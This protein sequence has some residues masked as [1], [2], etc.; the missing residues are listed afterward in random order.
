VPD[1]SS[2]TRVHEGSGMTGSPRGEVLGM[3]GERRILSEILMPRLAASKG[4]LRDIGDDCAEIGPVAGDRTLLVTTDPCPSPVVFE[5]EDKDY[6]HYG[7]MTILINVSDLAAM[8]AIPMGIAVSTV[9][10]NEMRV[11]DYHRFLDG[12]IEAADE[13]D[14]PVIG[15]NIKDGPAFTST[16]TALGS[17]PIGRVLKRT[18]ARP[19]DKICVVGRMGLFW[20]AV[21]R[22]MSSPRAEVCERCERDLHDAL[23]RPKAR[24]REAQVLARS[25]LVTACMDA[26]DGVGAC[27]AELAAKNRLDLMVDGAALVPDEPVREVAGQLGVDPR[28][29]LLSWGNWELVFTVRRDATEV[30]LDLAREHN[31][32]AAIIGEMRE[33]AGEVWLTSADEKYRLTDFSSERFTNTSY[34]THGVKSYMEWLIDAPL[35][36]GG[37]V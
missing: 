9:M 21:L 35:I 20:A 4:G 26:S 27:L 37:E 32:P 16:G 14:C 2:E 7:Y 13:W 29:L 34:F 33:G 15:G 28:K 12:L 5:I 25:G 6:W 31:F 30:M 36:L 10:P 23:H 18:G 19:G 17:A 8:G 11:S 22:S 3:L 24:L 1:G